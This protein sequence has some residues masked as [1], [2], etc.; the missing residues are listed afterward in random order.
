MDTTKIFRYCNFECVFELA[1]WNL[2]QIDAYCR[3]QSGWNAV[4][5]INGQ[6]QSQIGWCDR[7]CIQ[8]KRFIYRYNSVSGLFEQSEYMELIRAESNFLFVDTPGLANLLVNFDWV[9][10]RKV[11][12]SEFFHL[13][14]CFFGSSQHYGDSHI[15]HQNGSELRT[16][17]HFSSLAFNQ[18]GE[19]NNFWPKTERNNLLFFP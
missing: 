9:V 10:L 12:V 19:Q 11:F 17:V 8:P 6:M 15:I 13:S 2:M 16:C 5:E 7:L 4:F 1:V 3:W 14:S 18:D